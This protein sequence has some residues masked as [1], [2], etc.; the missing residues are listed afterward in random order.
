MQQNLQ[1]ILLGLIGA[2]Q[3]RP[4]VALLLGSGVFGLSFYERAHPGTLFAFGERREA[5]GDDRGEEQVK[6]RPSGLQH[7]RGGDGSPG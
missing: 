2:Q 3:P 7:R 6:R 1:P 5:R 4:Q